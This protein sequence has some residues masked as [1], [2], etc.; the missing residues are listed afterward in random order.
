MRQAFISVILKKGRIPLSC[1]SFS[2]I[3][4]LN[5]DAKILAKVLAHRLETVLPSIISPNQTG[6][7]QNRYSFFNIRCLFN[8]L[9]SPSPPGVTDVVL[10]LDAEKAFDRVESSYLFSTLEKFGF[11][12]TFISWI[13]LIY[14]S[15]LAAVR[16]NNDLSSFFELQRGTWSCPLSLLLFPIAMEPLALALLCR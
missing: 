5:T 8:I 10:L 16:T 9:Y 4:L 14:T 15:P 1:N 11:G 7:V 13:R 6:F 2:P 12:H 3:S